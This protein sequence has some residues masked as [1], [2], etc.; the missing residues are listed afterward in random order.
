M[1]YPLGLFRTAGAV[2]TIPSNGGLLPDQGINFRYFTG[3]DGFVRAMA[4]VK[5]REGVVW[6]HGLG[7]A[8][9]ETASHHER[10]LASIRGEEDWPNQL[11]RALLSG[12][13]KERSLKWPRRLIF[14]IHG[15]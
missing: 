14:E 7:V 15:E 10:M 8:H 1:S 12:M 4:D 11:T 5:E 2:S 13:I 6:I 3:D 9:D